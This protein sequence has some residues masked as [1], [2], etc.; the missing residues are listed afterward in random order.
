MVVAR[1][2]ELIATIDFHVTSEC[3][4]DCP[5]CWG[6]RDVEPA[7]RK[8]EALRIIEKV[9][10]HGI[11]RI[12][13]TGGDPLQRR[14]LGA[15][16]K[17]AKSL[18]LEVALSTTGDRLTRWFLRRYGRFI[19]LVSIPLDGSSEEVS[20]LTKE[21]GHFTAVKRALGFLEKHPRVD[22][23]VC[24]PLTRLN[25]HDLRNM[26]DLVAHWAESAPNRVFY[27][28][29]NIYPRA[30]QEV[31]WDAYLIPEE[32]FRALSDH[33]KDVPGVKVNFLSRETLDALYVLIFPDG[34]LY[35]PIGPD[36]VRLGRFL[37]IE[38]LDDVVRSAGF[39]AE[40]HLVHSK[41]WGKAESSSATRSS[42]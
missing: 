2:S 20:S 5:Y 14:D 10:Q 13:F 21:K 37:D 16:A 36:Y 12:V 33:V 19:D 29:F 38:D 17:Y 22:V 23:K 24:T 28:V 25:A 7:V 6:P 27:N 40:K 41:G 8:K 26:L 4:Q 3:S 30:M 11:K 18:G 32:E 42:S 34:E 35:L 1:Q 15:L 9:R 31:D 39:Q